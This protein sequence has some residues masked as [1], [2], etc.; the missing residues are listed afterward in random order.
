MQ[1][2]AVSS[3]GDGAWSSSRTIS[4]ISPDL[5]PM[6]AAI[7]DIDLEKGTALSMTLPAAT[8]GDLPITYAVTGRP[9]GM[10]FNS[11]TRLLTWPAQSASAS[12]T[13]TYTA[14]DT[15]DDVATRSFVVRVLVGY[16][17]WSTPTDR[18]TWLLMAVNRGTSDSDWYREGVQGSLFDSSNALFDDV[19]VTGLRINRIR[20]LS[21][22][23]LLN[24]DGAT[25]FS[26]QFGADDSPLAEGIWHI[27]TSE[28]E[29]L[30]TNSILDQAGGSFARW[31]P[32]VADDIAF[33]G[34]VGADDR[35][36]LA[37]TMPTTV[38]EVAGLHT[39]QNV[40]LTGAVVRA[41]PASRSVAGAHTLQNVMLTGAVVRAAPASRS[42]AGAHTLQNVMLTG[43][44]VRAAVA[45][46]SVA[47][48]HTLQNVMLT[49]AVVRAA[50]AARSVAG[51]HTLQNVMLTG[52]V[53]RAAVAARSVA[54]AH[55]LQNVMLTGAVVRAA[56]LP[57]L[58]AISD[59]DLEKGTALS[60][61]LP[62][63]TS[64]DLPI[65]YAVTGRPAGML[66]NASTRLLTWPAQSASA[67]HTLTY[68]ATDTDDDVATRSFVVR[69]L[70]GYSDWSTPTDRE[71][72]LLMAVNR[73]TSDSDWYREGV[74]G[75]LFDGSNALFDDVLIPDI[76]INRIRWLSGDFLLNRA[77]GT[78]FSTQ[79]GAADSPLAEGIWHI[80]T[81]EGDVQLTNSIL[82]QAGGSFARWMPTA[83][84]DIAFI[85]GVGADDRF[86]LAFTMP[87][88]ER[89]VAGLHT[90]QNVMLTGAVVRAAPASRSVAGA[91]TLQNV[92]LTGAV[93]RAAI[94]FRTVAGAHTLQNVMLTG[95]VVRAAPA[96][97]S[98]AGLHTLQNVMLTGAVVRSAV[99]ARTVAGAHTLQNVMLTGAVVRAAPTSRSVAGAHTLQNVMLTGAV[100]RAAVAAR[101]VAGAHT[102]QNVMLTGAVVR[103]VLTA[104]HHLS[105]RSASSMSIEI[106][107]PPVSGAA[108]YDFRFRSFS[109][110]WTIETAV[111]LPYVKDGL[112]ASTRYE[113]QARAR[114][115]GGAVGPWSESGRVTTRSVRTAPDVMQRSALL[116]SQYK[117]STNLNVMLAGL[118]TIAQ[119]ELVDSLFLLDDYGSLDWATGRWL[120]F[121]GERLGLSRPNVSDQ[122]V[123]G[124]GDGTDRGTFDEV[125][126]FDTVAALESL[127]PLG[128]DQYLSLLRGRGLS[129][130][131]SA[132]VPD[133]EA[134]CTVMFTGG[135]WVQENSDGTVTVHATDGR[136]GFV[137]LVSNLG[138]LPRPAGVSMTIQE[139]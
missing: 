6:L 10:E 58:A 60:M 3:S 96:S 26:T 23:F 41:A 99:A 76:R 14:T 123:F 30:L 44:V 57:M 118:L 100:V 87:I 106:W 36:L 131:V 86:L 45:S 98:V 67:S 92:M 68:T 126:F 74:Y 128:D 117:Y 66:F 121:I 124:F 5:L 113:W 47:G 13:L 109:N 61:T 29:V 56:L 71:T 9:A 82:D 7:S 19:L 28:G 22:D 33:I 129:L 48:A 89:E 108:S 133:I 110:E 69:V 12:H 72:W 40:M 136:S 73:G 137:S 95:A 46:R 77:G 1:W 38:R 51:A 112:S 16:S 90:L 70:V 39:L 119:A 83:A 97:R 132:S 115:S 53:V 127:Q 75:S 94:V 107:L 35:F 81:S 52:A 25:Y 135:A 111:A 4:T 63:A 78:D 18:E 50:V 125:P 103:A 79:F 43:A 42:V 65:T 138:I 139:A 37:F 17:D 64:G 105:V 20:W 130:R 85:G 134:V 101:S 34:G 31:M 104:P 122:R 84:A 114:A 54:G 93:V 102:L 8:S 32:T 91:H 2:R 24:R 55:T 62:A 49:G 59:I 120:D 11:S 21:G 88:T 15:D 116:I 27:V 80:V